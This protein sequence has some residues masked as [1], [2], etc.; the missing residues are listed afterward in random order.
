[1]S[2]KSGR[3]VMNHIIRDPNVVLTVEHTSQ[4]PVLD[5]FHELYAPL[6]PGVFDI[7]A[8]AL[9]SPSRC[10]WTTADCGSDHFRESRGCGPD[11]I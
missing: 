8:M 9:K 10:C 1:M 11:R 2:E 4:K 6:D 3:F 5:R 7:T